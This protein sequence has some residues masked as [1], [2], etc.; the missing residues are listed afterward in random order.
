[1][2]LRHLIFF[3]ELAHTQHMAQAAENLGISQPSLSYAIKKLEAE[4]NVPLFEPD[5]RNIKLTPLGR[6]YLKYIN[7]SLNNLSHGNQLIK[8]LT[9]P[10]EG[11]VN[12]GFTYTLGQR[13]V[14]ELMTEFKKVAGNE[15][16]SFTLGQNDSAHL[17]KDLDDEKFDIVLSSHVDQIGDQDADSIFEFHPIVEQEIVLAVPANH[18][19]ALKRHVLMNDLTAYP[20]IIFSQNSGL[21]PLVDKILQQADGKPNIVYQIEEDHTI[22]GF[23]EYGLGIALIPNLAQLNSQKLVLRHVE[24]NQFRHQL[25]LVVKRDHFT[26]PSVQR[27]KKFVQQ[28][29]E[30]HFTSIGEFI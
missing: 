6:I 13:L 18:P 26:T 24:D 17:L 7:E 27:F 23:V 9:N 22:A 21:R 20:M 5:G 4:L 2:N 8:Q 16:I 28:Y 30:A 10:N 29:C 14:P 11:H 19:L 1:M 25:Y 12:L 15:K 3:R